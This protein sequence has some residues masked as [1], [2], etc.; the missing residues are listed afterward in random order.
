MPKSPFTHRLRSIPIRPP[1]LVLLLAALAGLLLGS[2]GRSGAETRVGG[3][4]KGT[5]EWTKTGNPYILEGDVMIPKGATL[6]IGPGVTVKA[7][8]NIA[9]QEGFNPFDLEF[10]VE[11]TLIAEGAENDTIYMS[12]DATTPNWGDWQGIV[13]QGPE[14]KV[15][16]KAVQIEFA[17]DGVRCNGGTVT[18]DNV[19]VSGC[20][21][22]GF[23]FV[24]GK[25][26][27]SNTLI[28]N[29]GNAGGTGI[30]VNVDREA[31][32]E[33]HNSVIVGAQNGMCFSRHSG[34]LVEGTVIS[35]C[36]SR[37]II[38]RNS[39]PTIRRS[40]ISGNQTGLLVSA[41][42]V[43]VVKENN[44]TENTLADVELNEYKGKPLKL[45]FTQNWWGES[46]I[47]LIEERVIDALDDASRGAYAVVDPVLKEAVPMPKPGAP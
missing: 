1:S 14:A 5:T 34:G 15:T 19:S 27:L 16:L 28:T 7:K 18:A 35:L 26:V 11:G 33:L 24:G 8:A 45:D 9:S 21:Q 2:P 10:Y 43:P 40:T 13:A 38:I 37:G 30:G 29:I 22:Y 46:G 23:Y 47:G 17:D 41:G 25:G 4:Y 42:A 31:T 39:N 44:F 3:T 6:K 12:S 20:S 36:V 32:V